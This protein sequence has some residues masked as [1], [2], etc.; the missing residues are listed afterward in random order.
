MYAFSDIF[1]DVNVKYNIGYAFISILCIQIGVNAFLI[2]VSTIIKAA[3]LFM[4]CIKRINLFHSKQQIK[5]QDLDFAIIK[6][7]NVKEKNTPI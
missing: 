4:K 6:D 5:S 7:T 2:I 1:D 3:K